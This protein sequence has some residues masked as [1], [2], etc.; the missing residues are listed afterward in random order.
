MYLSEKK[1]NEGQ[2]NMRSSDINKKLTNKD[3]C[4]ISYAVVLIVFSVFCSLFLLGSGIYG[5][6]LARSNENKIK[7][8]I[9]F[10][11]KTIHDDGLCITVDTN[12]KNIFAKC[13]V[14]NNIN[15]YTAVA[16]D[17]INQIPNCDVNDIKQNNENIKLNFQSGIHVPGMDF[18]M[19]FNPN[20]ASVADISGIASNPSF[21]NEIDISNKFVVKSPTGSLIF[22]DTGT[23]AAQFSVNDPSS[24]FCCPE[25]LLNFNN[26]FIGSFD[27]SSSSSSRC[28][29]N[30]GLVGPSIYVLLNSD[31]NQIKFCNCIPAS[32]NVFQE[33]CTSTLKLYGGISNKE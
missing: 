11:Q 2:Q 3:K 9:A 26:F 15:P 14:V 5:V 27:Q 13:P 4:L 28:N 31:I 29:T 30:M 20:T 25:H 18:S 12:L 8:E 6:Y 19:I 16:V 22:G 24:N 7:N 10:I 21:F 32:N 17:F 33:Y 1:M 23:V